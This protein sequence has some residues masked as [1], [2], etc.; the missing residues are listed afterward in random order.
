MIDRNKKKQ[1]ARLRRQRRVRAR[2]RGTAEKPRICVYRSLKSVY[3]QVIDDVA[4]KTL[5]AATDRDIP[6]KELA[7]LKKSG[8]GRKGKVAAA[9][10][11]GKAL[12]EKAVKKGISTVV[13]DR[14]GFAYT[15]RVAALAE[16][17]RDGG[18][19]F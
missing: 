10:A 4:G 3:A 17:A 15:G 12:A 7:A 16:G 13:F 2:V 14:N 19:K 11:V 9:Y 6:A 18:L 5:V 8:E 1:E